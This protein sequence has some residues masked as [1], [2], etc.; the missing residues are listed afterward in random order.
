[1]SNRVDSNAA[2]AAGR[3][4]GLIRWKREVRG[5]AKMRASF[6]MLTRIG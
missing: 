6:R 3:N 5:N 1:M 4:D 2:I